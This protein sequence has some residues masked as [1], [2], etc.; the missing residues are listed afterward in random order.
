MAKKPKWLNNLEA[1]ESTRAKSGKQETRLAKSLQGR[2]TI[3]SGAT[4]GQNDVTTDFCEIEAKTTDKGSFTVKMSDLEK[5][6][7]KC[8]AKKIPIMV[9]EMRSYHKEYAVIR[10]D[11]LKYLIEQANNEVPK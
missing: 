10:F 1:K 7:K 8:D 11:D 6:H 3:N 4:F 9:V 5:M 2:T